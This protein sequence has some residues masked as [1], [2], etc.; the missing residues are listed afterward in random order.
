MCEICSSGYFVYFDILW[1][2]T[3]NT[4]NRDR[5]GYSW[6]FM[7]GIVIGD[8]HP[9]SS[10]RNDW[11]H[12]PDSQSTTNVIYGFRIVFDF[13]WLRFWILF[14]AFF[15]GTFALYLQQFG[16]RICHFAWYLL[17][18]DMVTLHFAWYLLHFG[19]V[20]LHFA[21]HLLHLAMFAFHFAW[22]LP[23]FGNPTSHLQG[24]CYILVLQ[25]FM[26]VSWEFL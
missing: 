25:S 19:M 1:I 18:F 2:P 22:Y 16:T 5:I 8:H 11:R 17:H 20:T 4:I 13:F 12:Q 15:P 23:R 10:T 21:W 7:M 24:I 9:I 26:W 3:S 14:F 6:R